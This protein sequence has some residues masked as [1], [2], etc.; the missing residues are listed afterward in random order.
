MISVRFDS[1]ASTDSLVQFKIVELSWVRDSLSL[2][3]SNPPTQALQ[4]A[5]CMITDI[6][7]LITPLGRAGYY[8]AQPQM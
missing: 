1:T 6:L 7:L 5:N 8:N 2:P 3:N 4:H